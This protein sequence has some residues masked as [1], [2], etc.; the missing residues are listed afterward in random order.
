M[1]EALTDLPHHRGFLEPKRE[2]IEAQDP[3][4]TERDRVLAEVVGRQG[5]APAVTRAVDL[6]DEIHPVPAYV[7]VDP[8][9]GSSSHHLSIGFG[10][11][12]ASAHPREVQL[13]Q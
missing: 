7:E 13:S 9:S 8:S 6:H 2:E 3:V 5:Q 11:A 1:A 4:A 10:D 12:M